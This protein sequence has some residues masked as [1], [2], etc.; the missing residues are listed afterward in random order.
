MFSI[1]RRMNFGSPLWWSLDGFSNANVLGAWKFSG[2]DNENIAKTDL[3]GRN[4]TLTKNNCGWSSAGYTISI[5]NR[6]GDSY[7]YLN[8]DIKTNCQSIVMKI[9]SVSRT[10]ALPLSGFGGVGIWLN[11]PIATQAFWY[12]N[13]GQVGISH[14][15][16]K[17][18][19]TT[20]DG[21]LPRTA[22][23]YATTGNYGS[24]G[25]VGF[26]LDGESIYHNGALS[27]KAVASYVHPVGGDHGEWT[28]FLCANQLSLVGGA[29]PKYNPDA[30][31]DSPAKWWFVGSFVI[32]MLAV[33]SKKLDQTEHQKIYKQMLFI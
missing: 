7:S 26:T 13:T 12:D 32:E 17:N 21:T 24:G 1:K 10:A 22:V 5:D 25:V 3:T 11:I 30:G 31:W 19:S 18:S 23:Q 6:N 27:S 20:G 15:N 16:G 8:S 14:G 29:G 9:S 2:R 33:Y 28:A 4:A